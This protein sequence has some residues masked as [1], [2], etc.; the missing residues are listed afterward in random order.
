MHRLNDP[1]AL[2]TIPDRPADHRHAPLQGGVA[3]KPVGPEA[4]KQFLPQ[5]DTVPVF[6]QIGQHR[7]PLP[8][9]WD[10]APRPLE[11]VALQI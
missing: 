9:E 5:D 2:T 10:H 11:F 1:L 6:D 7:E 3:D 4:V 8:V